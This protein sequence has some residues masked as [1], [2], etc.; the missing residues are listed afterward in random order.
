MGHIAQAISQINF[1][2]NS[3]FRERLFFHF[4]NINN[5]FLYI[6]YTYKLVMRAI[7]SLWFPASV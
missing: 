3:K 6:V 2:D 4:L 7:A 1:I 5:P